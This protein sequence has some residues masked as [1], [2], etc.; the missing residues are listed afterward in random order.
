LVLLCAVRFLD[1]MDVSAMVTQAALRPVALLAGDPSRPAPRK[2]LTGSVH[3][4]QW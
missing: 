3:S 2:D 4:N 1:G